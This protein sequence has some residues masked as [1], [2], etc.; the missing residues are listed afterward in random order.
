MYSSSSI[1]FLSPGQK[2]KQRESPVD[3][4]H[5]KLYVEGELG[6]RNR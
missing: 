4:N 2:M 6:E 3:E 5:G 1:K